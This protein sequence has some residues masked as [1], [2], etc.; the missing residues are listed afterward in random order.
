MLITIYDYGDYT[1]ESWVGLPES[2][3]VKK[4]RK[5]YEESDIE[6][7]TNT[8]GIPLGKQKSVSL[9]DEEGIFRLEYNSEKDYYS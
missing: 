3:L 1:V 7:I 5:Q 4:V 9:E 6:D 2:E 8:P